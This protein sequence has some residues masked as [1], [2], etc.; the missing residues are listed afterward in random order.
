MLEA[1]DVQK[2]DLAF[3]VGAASFTIGAAEAAPE[4]KAAALQY[5]ARQL[6]SSAQQFTAL[7]GEEAKP[8]RAAREFAAISMRSLKATRG[9][10]AAR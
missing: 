4:P 5:A 9:K 6:L 1:H 8:T 10:G 2:A 7:L 3:H